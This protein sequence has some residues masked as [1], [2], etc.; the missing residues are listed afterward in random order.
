MFLELAIK[1]LVIKNWTP[2]ELEKQGFQAW[3]G[4]W[5]LSTPSL[6]SD[7][8]CLSPGYRTNKLCNPGVHLT[9]QCL[10]FLDCKMGLIIAT[11]LVGLLRGYN[12]I[13]KQCLAYS[14]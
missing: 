5:Q 2:C 14:E 6:T 3:T 12:E 9:S 7:G 10:S 13:I 8:L 1:R 4:S 11:Y